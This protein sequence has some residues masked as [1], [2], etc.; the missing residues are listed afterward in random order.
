MSCITGYL[1]FLAEWRSSVL[2]YDV[3]SMSDRAVRPLVLR[4]HICMY[5]GCHRA[6]SPSKFQ[7]SG[8]QQLWDENVVMRR[9]TTFRPTT[10]RIYDSVTIRL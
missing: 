6:R 5:S 3:H 10:D 9:I 4:P 8:G 2:L 7:Q 1:L